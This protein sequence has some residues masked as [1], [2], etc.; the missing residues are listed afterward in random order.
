M[1]LERYTIKSREVVNNLQLLANEYSHQELTEIHLLMSL[2]KTEDSLMLP[3]LQKID[4]P[5]RELMIE[6]K[7]ELEKLPQ[8]NGN[9]QIYLSNDLNNIFIEAEK[10]AKNLQD[11]YISVEHILLA[12]VLKARMT[13]KLFKKYSIEYN[14]ILLALKEI[15]GN[16]RVTDENPEGKYQALEKY[17]RNLTKLAKQGKLDPVIGRDEEIRRVIQILSRRRKN[18]PVLIGEP[19]VGKTA[20]IEGL[21]KRIIDN[22]IPENLKNKE[23]LELDMAALIAGAKFRGEFEDRLKAVLKE[24]EANEGKIVLFIDEIHTVVGAGAAE[25][26]VDASNMLK[27]ALARGSLHCVGATTLNEYRKYIEKDAALERRFQPVIVNEPNV[28]DSI[29]I[30]R[31][32]KEKYEVH[33][34]V[35]ITDGALVAAAYLS[36][37]YISDRFLPD[38]AIDLVDEACAQ[39][40]MEIDSMPVELDELE[41]K[42]KQLEIEKLSMKKEK[43]DLSKDRLKKIDEDISNFK[44]SKNSLRIKWDYEKQLLNQISQ[45]SE[46]IEEIKIKI[47]NSERDGYLDKAAELKYGSLPAKVRDLD[48]LKL[49][50][51]D[52][53]LENR[54]LKE[55][56]DDELIAEIVSKWT[57]IPITKLIESEMQKL[58]KMEDILSQKVIGQRDGIEA[59]S[60]AIRRSRSG[61]AEQD[62]PIGSFL[63]L[64]P[65]GVGKTELAKTLA[66]FL[67]DT[68]KAII[69]IDMS[70]Y[71]EKHSV[72]RL[73]GAPPG[74]VGYDE[75]GYLTESVRRNPYSVILF[76][77]IE[78]AHPD[79]FNALLQIFDDG[80]LTDGQGRTV[81]F[82]NTIIIM[83]SN[84]GAQMIYDDNSDD[85]SSIKDSLFKLLQQYFKPEF[86]NRLDETIVFHKL[87]KL[88]IIEIVKLNLQKLSKRMLDRRIQLEFTDKVIEKIAEE[89]FEPHFGARPLKRVIQRDIENKLASKIIAGEVKANHIVSVDY[90]ND[91]YIFN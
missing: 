34:G 91:K 44:E 47:E 8:V 49:K 68:Q 74:Y 29:S 87:S 43:D 75:G 59:L 70:E 67:F 45:I 57:H 79:V 30:L 7:K 11:D 54:I 2:L 46:E 62:K 86:L 36:N 58:L 90:S 31:G 10:Q 78:K 89:G 5:I 1:N 25:G 24:V 71:M 28:E 18:N 83:T 22:D 27:P 64:G 17:A 23:I 65:T 3:L 61:L 42:I 38:K 6:V 20:I 60:N 85:I 12:L 73:I 4:C 21:A 33:H 84:I 82:K 55:N 63:F 72:S 39:L 52:I 53:P 41:R 15:R 88:Q 80:R 56:V 66:E 14:S 50:L 9:I 32:I 48:E 40:K 76:D 26:S 35:Q 81:D 19:G 37:R 69:R 77:E 13:D 51:S 16:Q